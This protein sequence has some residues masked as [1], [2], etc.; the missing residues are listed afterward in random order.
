MNTGLI[1]TSWVS[2]EKIFIPDIRAAT[3]FTRASLAEEV[4]LKAGLVLPVVV[5][6]KTVAVLNFFTTHENILDEHFIRLTTTVAGQLGSF[7]LRKYSE[8]ELFKAHQELEERVQART[9]ELEISNE[10]LRQQSA[11]AEALRDTALA[12]NST[13]ELPDVLQRI[14]ENVKRV[15]RHET[16]DIM[17]IEGDWAHVVGSRG[18]NTHVVTPLSISPIPFRDW[19]LLR[20]MVETGQP[21]VIE[22]IQ[23]HPGWIKLGGQ[24]WRVSY[25]G[26]PIRQQDEVIGFLNI[27]SVESAFFTPERVEALQIFADQAALAIQNAKLYQESQTLAAMQ[28]RER[29]ARDLH[30]AVSQTLFSASVVA[31]ALPRLSQRDPRKVPVLAEQIQRLTRGAQAEMRTLLLELRP[32][33]LNDADLKVLLFQLVEATKSRKKIHF[34]IEIDPVDEIAPDTKLAL[35]RIAQEALNNITKH[36]QATQGA[37]RFKQNNGQIEL[38]IADQGRGFDMDRVSSTHLGIKIMRERAESIG[39]TLVIQSEPGQGTEIRIFCST[40]VS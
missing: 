28:E 2:Q 16:A 7:I 8:D 14:L 37:I 1:G 21:L 22:N 9:A 15:V 32:A 4:G 34:D 38:L 24:E 18:Y 17:L 36:S 20:Q 19:P 13:L 33:A 10:R 39:G 40:C 3:E 30:D 29:L 26:L 5:R 27:T 11:L 25:A 23:T 35:Y 31:E 12:L 6:S